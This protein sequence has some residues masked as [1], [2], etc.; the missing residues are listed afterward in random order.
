MGEELDHS[1]RRGD[2]LS[3]TEDALCIF[4]QDNID[5]VCEEPLDVSIEALEVHSL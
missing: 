1:P 4:T 3:D 2:N 5:S